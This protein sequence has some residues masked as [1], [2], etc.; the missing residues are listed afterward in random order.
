MSA[1]CSKRGRGRRDAGR[2]RLLAAA[3]PS[4]R[5]AVSV[6]PSSS[7]QRPGSATTRPRGRFRAGPPGDGAARS[8]RTRLGIEREHDRRL[9]APGVAGTGRRRTRLDEVETA[10]SRRQPVLA[11]GLGDGDG[12]GRRVAAVGVQ[13]EDA[14][15]AGR[16]RGREQVAKNRAGRCRRRAT[17]SRRRAGDGR[18]R[19][20]RA[21]ARAGSSRA[22]R[23]RPPRARRRRSRSARPCRCE[24]RAVLLGRADREDGKA[25][26][27]RCG[28]LLARQRVP[29]PDR[30]HADSRAAS[31]SEALGRLREVAGDGV[32]VPHR[33][34]R[35]VDRP[36]DLDDAP[37]GQRGWK[38]QPDGSVSDAGAS[39]STTSVAL[40]H[41][42]RRRD[43]G[44]QRMRVR[45]ARGSRRE[46]RRGASSTIRP[47]YITA[48]VSAM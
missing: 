28:D 46:P 31:A 13:D 40:L 34:Q 12:A 29:T 25:S 17:A 16:R 26:G 39:L 27:A 30:A 35:R 42:G 21:S 32:T 10:R 24:V 2:E 38:R 22:A 14:P 23:P 11:R 37:S 3:P 7:C 9:E 33:L 45:M 41:A 6:K 44:E 4:P 1:S 18:R 48:I 20:R 8:S 5:R 47:R 19:R 15:D 36:A 43:R